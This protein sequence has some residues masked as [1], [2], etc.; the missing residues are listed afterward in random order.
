M[1]LQIR[2]GVD[3]SGAG[4]RLTITP[5]TGELLY[6]TDTKKLYI[7]DST[8]VG[9]NIIGDG[10]T[11]V[12]DDTSPQLGGNLDVN[13]RSIVS[14]SNGNITIAPSG[15]G[16][17]LINGTLTSAT[18]ITI[19]PTSTNYLTT[20]ATTLIGD[21]DNGVDGALNIRTN[22]YTTATGAGLSFGQAHNNVAPVPT[23]LY[24]ARGSHALP[25]A[26]ANNDRLG[27]IVFA[28][29]DGTAYNPSVSISA[30]I[31]G[32]VA[33]SST[34]TKLLFST[35]NGTSLLPR[36]EISETGVLKTNSIQ[37]YSGTTLTLTATTVNVAGNMQ[38]NAQS[39][40]RFADADSSNWVAFQA[41]TT[42]A[43]NVTWTLP[44]IDGTGGQVL[45]TNG[46]GTLSWATV[47][48]GA[49]SSRTT[50][51][52]TTG[53]IADTAVGNVDVIGFKSYALFT[54]VTSAA[55]RVRIYTSIAARTADAG[56]AEGV[57]PTQDAGVIADVVATGAQSI[58][59][60]PGVFGF[61]AEPTGAT[62]NIPFA[63]TNKS[64]G[65]ASIIATIS[66][67]QLEA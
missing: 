28:G 19:A 54:V 49:L 43:T 32:S 29:Y 25:A 44:A 50:K 17:I 30:A 61:N 64:G 20:P 23:L 67:L 40:L 53:S 38:L 22:T 12:V 10:L 16:K 47:G 39:D 18:A 60:A 2:R 65:T 41:P 13:G 62:T 5:T 45:S 52:A 63:I 51:V 46:G 6:T 14:A 55:C 31:V 35:H 8:T 59:I 15:T 56:R 4:G 24:R 26:V 37:N 34:P 66:L 48:G 7:G 3:G 21:A 33:T 27:A 9:G 11:N 58:V 42:V 36:A 1:A 57:L